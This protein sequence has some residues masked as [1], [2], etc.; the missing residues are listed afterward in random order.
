MGW[1]T[2]C[3]SVGTTLW[4]S[5]HLSVVLFLVPTM[6]HGFG[7]TPQSWPVS[8]GPAPARRNLS[9]HPQEQQDLGAADG[10]SHHGRCSVWGS[11]E[12]CPTENLGDPGLR[13]H[14]G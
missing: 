10:A 13:H 12:H 14:T 1:P 4:P 5:P 11:P 7:G 8:Y 2:R 9:C 6:R 3:F